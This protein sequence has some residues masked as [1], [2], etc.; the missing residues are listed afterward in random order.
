MVV[1]DRSINAVLGGG[2]ANVFEDGWAVGHRLCFTPGAEAIAE[3]VHVGVGTDAGIAKQVPGA[4]HRLASFEDDETLLRAFA[5][6]VTRAADSRQPGSHDNYINVRHT[7]DWL[8][9]LRDHNPQCFC[10]PFQRYPRLLR[11]FHWFEAITFGH[12]GAIACCF[13]NQLLPGIA[14]NREV[15]LFIRI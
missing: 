5:L 6:Q 14:V 4:A 3:C 8:T 1:A 10:R 13:D 15:A 7:H 11:A 9:D 12:I 2:V